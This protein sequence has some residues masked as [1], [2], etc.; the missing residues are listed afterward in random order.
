MKWPAERLSQGLHAAT[1]CADMP[2]PW[3]DASAGT[4][5]RREA[6][7]REA[8]KLSA[9]DLYPFDRETAT[10]NGFV[11]Q[12]LHWPPVPVPEPDGPRDLPRVPVLLLAGDLDLS[13]PLEW[14]RQ[15]AAHAPRGQLVIAKGTGHGVQRQGNPEALAA[16]RRFVADALRVTPGSLSMAPRSL[17]NGTIAFGLV[18]VPVKVYTATESKSVHFHHVH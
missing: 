10:G 12:C 15:A 18:N 13:T 14:A 11:Q 4:A 1:L 17:W 2:A 8:A 9:E 7:E 5:G 3:G 6:L 16:V